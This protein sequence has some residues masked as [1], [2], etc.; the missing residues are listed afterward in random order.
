[1]HVGVTQFSPY[2]LSSD[3][4]GEVAVIQM[5]LETLEVQFCGL[6]GRRWRNL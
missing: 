6:L 5:G 3:F 1:M 4:S 2:Q